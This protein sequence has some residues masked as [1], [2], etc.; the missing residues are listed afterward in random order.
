MGMI[1][2]MRGD[3]EAIDRALTGVADGLRAALTAS[4]WTERALGRRKLAV[5]TRPAGHGV[6]ATA[7]I[8]R[9]S[10]FRWPDGWPVEI[11]VRVGV[12]YEPA[13]DLMPLL[14]L[15]PAATLV[16]HPS[17]A[18][19][20]G[21]V[22]QLQ[23]EADVPAFTRRVVD[24][25]DEH[26]SFAGQFP[27]A[28]AIEAALRAAGPAPGRD[29]DRNAKLRLTLLA[30]TGRYEE[31]RALL[32]RYGADNGTGQVD[33]RDRR[34]IRQLTRWL[35]AGGPPIPPIA[36]TLARLPAVTDAPRPRVSWSDARE[37]SR[38]QREAVDAVR[39]RAEGKSPDELTRVVT[40]E[41]A[42][43]NLDVMPS[44]VASLT[45]LLQNERKPFGRARS[46]LRALRMLKAGGTDVVRA[47]KNRSD[48]TPEWLRPP[49]R[50][51]YPVHLVGHRY[52]TVL[53]DSGTGDWLAAVSAE[54]PHRIGRTVPV[55]VWLT[56]E[57]RS[58]D[59]S[60]ELVAH[61]G[62]R[63]VGTVRGS[64]TTAYDAFMQ[65]A[66][67]FDEDPYLHGRLSRPEAEKQTPP[68]LEIPLP[69]DP[70]ENASGS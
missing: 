39:T 44:T 13:L 64:E 11:G 58:K 61:I 14:T 63:R 59:G 49:E 12:G 1:H 47:I 66:A 29:A 50:A 26:R 16:A 45:G 40:A 42:R 55:D 34:F 65:A 6:L 56:R 38:L 20:V 46:T 51:S 43:R 32:A 19:G 4:G 5:F 67:F 37:K 27:D 33:R 31:T 57:T 10:M 2:A 69:S 60:T 35:A 9:T 24:L 48:P 7:E 36:D 28:A 3:P 21:R 23:A 41:Y 22:V 15:P 25:I 52:T 18:D 8:S 53:L 54:A 70:V 62:D 30:A 17:M 68:M